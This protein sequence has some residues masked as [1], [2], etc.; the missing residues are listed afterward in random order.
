M[1]NRPA[2]NITAHRFLLDK[3]VTTFHAI[4]GKTHE[5][6]RN[7]VSADVS[8]FISETEASSIGHTEENYF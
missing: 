5:S 1:E 7:Y 8:N 2:K 3:E 6:E 4:T